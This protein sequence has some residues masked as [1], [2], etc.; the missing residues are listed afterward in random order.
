MQNDMSVPLQTSMGAIQMSMQI[1]NSAEVV[2]AQH[3][4]DWQECLGGASPVAPEAPREIACA[5][6]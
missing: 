1:F 4:K 2:R 3:T 6:T 5:H